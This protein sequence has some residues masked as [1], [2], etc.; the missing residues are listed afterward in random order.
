VAGN[1][2]EKGFLGSFPVLIPEL[3][4]FAYW[5]LSEVARSLARIANPPQPVAG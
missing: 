1:E 4:D 3:N 2:G 5:H